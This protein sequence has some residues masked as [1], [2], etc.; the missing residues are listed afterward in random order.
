MYSPIAK[1]FSEDIQQNLRRTFDAQPG[2][3]IAFVADKPKVVSAALAALRVHTAELRGL[4]PKDQFKFCWVLDFPLLDYND[5]EQRFEACHH[6]FTSPRPEDLSMLEKDPGAVKAL[7]H[8]II[9]NGVE[10][11][12]GS[13]RIHNPDIQ[14]RVFRLLNISREEAERKFGFLLDALKYGAPP[15]GGI[16]LGLDRLVMLLLGLDTIRDVIAFPKTQKA[17]CLMTQA[18]GEVDARQLKELGIRIAD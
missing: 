1:F 2:D 17:I 13:I 12:G 4:I 18:P 7:A 9:L 3:L 16:A 14:Q 5:E 8:D 10:I 6:P 11:G 15:H